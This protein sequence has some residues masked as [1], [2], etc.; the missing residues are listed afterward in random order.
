MVNQKDQE[1]L[2]DYH[3]RQLEEAEAQ[4]VVGRL[5]ADA[6]FKAESRAIQRV[7]Q[8]LNTYDVTA[9]ADLEQRVL[10]GIDS[11]LRPVKMDPERDGRPGWGGSL[12]SMRDMVAAAAMI[13]V[14][15]GL[16]VPA[17]SRAREQT[18]RV[19]CEANLRNVGLGM[20]SYAA[21]AGGHMPF[22]GHSPGAYWLPVDKPG[23]RVADN[24]RHAYMLIRNKMARPEDFV[25]P[26]RPDSVV[27]VADRPEIFET[28]PELRNVTYSLQCMAGARPRVADHPNMPIM[29]DQTP[30][31]ANGRFAGLADRKVNSPNH[32]HD[33]QNV[34]LMDGR[35]IW[36]ENPEAGIGRDNI[37]LI[38]GHEQDRYHGIEAP[39]SDTDA[40]LVP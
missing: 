31:F 18:R 38:Q 25:C 7:L 28:F 12:L 32:G 17:F 33:G 26:S 15:F 9:P 23:A 24:S 40:F 30:L 36:A 5:E 29:A 35:V 34:L 20:Q 1:R 22:A 10:Q 16:L 19:A 39:K 13:A 21:A 4:A 14:A 27:M 6:E 3:L 2:L 37:W 8:L 11:R